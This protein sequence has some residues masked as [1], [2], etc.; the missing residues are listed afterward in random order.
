MVLGAA[1]ML[2]IVVDLTELARFVLE[3]QIKADLVI[4]HYQYFSLQII[5]TI[6]P[7]V[8]LLTTLITFGLLSRTNEITAAKA[9]GVSL[10]RLAVP[11]VAAGLLMGGLA[12]LLDFTILPVTNARKAELRRVIKGHDEPA[13]VRRATRQWF[14]SQAPDGGGFIYNYLH[15]NPQLRLLQ[16]F[17][18]FRFDR[19]HRLTGHLYASELR[20]IGG[21]WIM[22]DGWARELE[23]PRVIDYRTL[24]GPGDARPATRPRVLLDRGQELGGDELLRAARVRAPD[25]VERTVG[26]RSRHPAPQQ[27]RQPGGV[28]GHGPG[29][30]PLRVPLRASGAR[31]TVSASPSCS[32]SCCRW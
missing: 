7:I 6:A 9:L 31:S 16:R 8:V 24:P 22:L 29:R 5:Y 4:E 27:D 2:Y 25:Q 15:F 20:L 17:Q 19:A 11:V 18:S 1:I 14:Y 23:G 10:Y 21:S 26:T 12:A 13:G 32:A 30:A 3:N 28:R